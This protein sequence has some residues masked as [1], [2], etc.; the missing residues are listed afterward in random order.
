[1]C[2]VDGLFLG[3]KDRLSAGCFKNLPAPT[4]RF[5]FNYCH[6]DGQRSWVFDIF[7]QKMSGNVSFQFKKRS[8]LFIRVHNE[9]LTVAAMCVSN[10]DGSPG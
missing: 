9:A 7:C 3:Q 4:V 8:Q 10:P 5:D 1:L 6:R 2:V